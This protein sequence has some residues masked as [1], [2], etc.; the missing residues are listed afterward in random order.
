MVTYRHTK[1]HFPKRKLRCWNDMIHAIYNRAAITNRSKC[2]TSWSIK[3]LR[4]SIANTPWFEI[5]K[6]RRNWRQRSTLTFKFIRLI[7]QSKC[8]NRKGKLKRS[9]TKT[10]K[11][12]DED[13][14][15]QPNFSLQ[16]NNI[17]WTIFQWEYNEKD[18]LI[19][20]YT[21]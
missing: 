13:K 5:H 8:W 16:L 11:S 2:L 18:I 15:S 10:I 6:R 4:C 14:F 17:C 9:I 1:I 21:I 7:F 19:C 12:N 3:M 20:M